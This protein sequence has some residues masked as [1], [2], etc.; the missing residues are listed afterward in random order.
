M[1]PSVARIRGEVKGY[2]QAFASAEPQPGRGDGKA[3]GDALEAT[4]PANDLTDE[5]DIAVRL[6]C[7]EHTYEFPA[8]WKLIR[9]F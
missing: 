5:V 7:S 2:N 9:V 4:R 3:S 8:R 1:F 6:D